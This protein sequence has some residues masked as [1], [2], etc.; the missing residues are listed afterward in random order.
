MSPIWPNCGYLLWS[1]SSVLPGELVDA[2]TPGQQGANTDDRPRWRGLPNADRASRAGNSGTG[3]GRSTLC[4]CRPGPT[5][6]ARAAGN[7]PLAEHGAWRGQ[8]RRGWAGICRALWQ[9]ATTTKP[10]RGDGVVDTAAVFGATGV[11]SQG[12]RR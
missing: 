10:G 11:W 1:C 6:P 3:V 12:E 7:L 4:R 9:L 2:V 5:R 8:P